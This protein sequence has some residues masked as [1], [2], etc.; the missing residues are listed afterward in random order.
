MQNFIYLHL[1]HTCGV[2]I[3]SISSDDAYEFHRVVI[4]TRFTISKCGMSLNTH[5]SYTHAYYFSQA[6][7][8]LWNCKVLYY[9]A[10]L[11]LINFFKLIIFIKQFYFPCS[12]STHKKC[13]F[14]K[15][16]NE[17]LEQ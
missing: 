11:S 3:L 12:S 10:T 6:S 5:T 2:S 17:S 4:Y 7:T 9:S 8:K 14:K 13:N 1:L 16:K 15:K